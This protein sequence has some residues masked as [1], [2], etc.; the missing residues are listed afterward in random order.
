MMSMAAGLPV[1][2]PSRDGERVSWNVWSIHVLPRYRRG[3]AAAS[4]Q[5]V[6]EFTLSEGE[7]LLGMT[8]DI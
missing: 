3:P 6:A 8:F 5:L 4:F 1:C 7:G 2:A